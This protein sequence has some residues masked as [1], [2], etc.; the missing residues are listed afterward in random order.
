MSV[1]NTGSIFWSRKSQKIPEIGK[2][3]FSAIFW[4]L[5]MKKLHLSLG[6]LMKFLW[7]HNWEET[8]RWAVSINL[9][10]Q[11]GT[12]SP[13]CSFVNELLSVQIWLT[14]V[15][16][17]HILYI[18]HEALLLRHK[19]TIHIFSN[20]WSTARLFHRTFQHISPPYSFLTLLFVTHLPFTLS[21]SHPQIQKIAFPH[22]LAFT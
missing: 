11:S 2:F 22:S 1:L 8:R 9:S 3:S 7:G 17:H 6:N 14:L 19:H 10:S 15:F 20:V 5:M 16:Q 21:L 12:F 18:L 4:F 13:Q